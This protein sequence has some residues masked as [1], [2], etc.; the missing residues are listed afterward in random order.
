[1]KAAAE[2][3]MKGVLCYT[4]EQV[5]SSD[6]IGDPHSSIYD[7]GAGIELNANFFKV[8]SWYDNEAGYACRCI[9][10][11]Q[12]DGR[13]GRRCCV[14]EKTGRRS[15]LNRD[16]DARSGSASAAP[17]SSLCGC[18]RGG[19][20]FR[21]RRLGVP[22]F[23]FEQRGGFLKPVGTIGQSLF[24]V[25]DRGHERLVR[26]AENHIKFLA[27]AAQLPGQRTERVGL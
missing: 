10:M 11:L 20:A 7:A 25:R 15:T 21:L 8:I 17:Y 3:P 24:D 19:C 9:D 16:G 12:D 2:G 5:A 22:D 23:R 26:F 6:F 18:S 14:I 27:H 1:M 13:E 4:E